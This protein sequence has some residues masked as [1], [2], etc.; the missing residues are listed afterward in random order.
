MVILFHPYPHL[1]FLSS[2]DY[3]KENSV[4]QNNISVKSRGEGGSV[5]TPPIPFT[6]SY[7]GKLLMGAGDGGRQ[8]ILPVPGYYSLPAF[9]VQSG[10]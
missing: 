6:E 4:Y 9:Y 1:L 7:S 8:M 10:P 2:T 5:K 3:F